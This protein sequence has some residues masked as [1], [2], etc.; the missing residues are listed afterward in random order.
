MY[1]PLAQCDKGSANSSINFCASSVA[2]QE[3]IGLT[4]QV[5]CKSPIAQALNMPSCVPSG[6]DGLP[7]FNHLVYDMVNTQKFSPPLSLDY[8]YQQMR[9]RAVMQSAPVRPT[10]RGKSSRICEGKRRSAIFPMYGCFFLTS[11]KEKKG[12]VL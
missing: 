6:N 10:D 1:I 2:T 9:V 5:P 3:S 7:I 4:P 8:F 11:R 12:P